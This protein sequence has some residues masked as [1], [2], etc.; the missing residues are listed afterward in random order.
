MR[1]FQRLRAVAH[2]L[3]MAV[4]NYLDMLRS[5]IKIAFRNLTRNKIYSLI[6]VSGLS[7]GIACCLLI[8][9]Y[10]KDELSFDKYHTNL[11][12]MYRV[13]QKF[14]GP[15]PTS[16]EEYQVWGCYPVGPALQNEFPEIEKI[17]TF[18][19][20]QSI[21]FQYEDRRFQENEVMF[22][23]S[24]V[25]DVFNWKLVE[26][27]P[28]DALRGLD[29]IVLT[30]SMAKKYF[31]EES[32]LG[33]I[34]IVD[35]ATDMPVMVSGVMEDVPANSHFKFDVLISMASFK[36]IRPEIFTAWPYVDFYTYFMTYKELDRDAFRA[37]LPA[38]I[39]KYVQKDLTYF[40]DIE[41][42][43][44]AYLHSQAVRQPGTTGSLANIY[45]F[46][47]IAVFI[48]LIAC[49]NFMNLSTARSMDRAKEVG[50]RKSLGAQRNGLIAQFLSEAMIL[51]LIATIIG[52]TIAS[53]LLPMFNAISGKQFEIGS[54]LSAEVILA[55]SGLSIL[56]GFLAGSYP[57]LLLS[58]FKPA[59]VLKGS[60]RNSS[61]GSF[62]RK[63]LVVFQFSL[64]VILIAGSIVVFSQLSH[65]R[66]Q[67][68]GY[69]KD[70]MIV[71]DFGWDGKV[72]E[73][74]NAVKN[75]LSQ[76]PS[77]ISLSAQRTVPGGFFPKA[78]TSIERYQGA[79]ENENVDL[80]EVDYDFVS[81][82]GMEIVAGRDYSREY[83]SDSTRAM[84][85]NEAAAASWGYPDP[86][87]IIGKKF[88]Q[89]GKQ[90]V[91]IGVVRNF[92]YRSLHHAVEPLT[93]RLTPQY[94][95]SSIALRVKG[96]DFRA[97]LAEAERIWN[98]VAPQRPFIYS[99]L[100][101]TFNEQYQSDERFGSLFTIF[102]GLAIFIA[103]FG[104]FGLTTYTVEQRT[105]EIGIR[106]VLGASV[107]N[108]VALLSKDFMKLVFIAIIIATPVA[109]S[110]MN[111]WLDGFAYRISI[112]TLMMIIPAIAVIAMA[113]AV[114]A[115]LAF[116]SATTNPVE[117]LRTE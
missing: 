101:D 24:T 54:L 76:V 22:A 16:P 13:V 23:D 41:R 3:T 49:I 34:M 104:L 35:N 77:V 78:G 68:T 83:P 6:N 2:D 5:I 43:G 66:A 42:V 102:A 12:R 50:V 8:T 117:A 20:K 112:S 95:M 70:Q 48:L 108:I 110:V 106:K 72:Q 116:R 58:R 91:I 99:F 115:A 114:V 113:L 14:G 98:H 15:E 44:D 80:Y 52:V 18:S 71:I 19:G 75:A 92:N 38:F 86:K 111:S 62:L 94:A 7:I 27:D 74:I 26:G 39:E 59:S 69:T 17:V 81:N 31:G 84:I 109:W 46:S 40:L 51:S 25:F 53:S 60:F 32:A 55:L 89:W 56:V 85:V 93:L 45:V 90:G 47:T 105:K 96:E 11:D 87:D 79:M 73:D 88:D 63:G 65:L 107:T 4:V 61:E 103:C 57:A 33:K 29:K 10:V 82:F 1:F 28:K 100:D 64:S 9:L 97:T 67:D 21:L 30:K 36:N 37:K